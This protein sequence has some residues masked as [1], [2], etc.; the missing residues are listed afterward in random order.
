MLQSTPQSRLRLTLKQ[1]FVITLVLLA[2]LLAV[3]F[4]LFFEGSRAALETNAGL[5]R[6]H[7]SCTLGAQVQEFLNAADE[8]LGE[9]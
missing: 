2:T 9:I 3:L 8:A 7:A 5:L 4:A 6:D 1:V